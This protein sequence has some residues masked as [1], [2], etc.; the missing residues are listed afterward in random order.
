MNETTFVRLDIVFATF[1]GDLSIPERRE[2]L[3]ARAKEALV[4]WAGRLR[5]EHLAVEV[6]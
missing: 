2:E 1:E 4:A 6:D 3:V 5:Y